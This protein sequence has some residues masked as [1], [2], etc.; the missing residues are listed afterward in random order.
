M[1]KQYQKPQIKSEI[2]LTQDV[3][4]VS[5]ETDNKFIQSNSILDDDFN[6]ES[7]L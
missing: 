5:E 1:K 3:L 2:L 6:I 7:L 4:R